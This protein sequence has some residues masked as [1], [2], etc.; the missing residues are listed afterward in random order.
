MEKSITLTGMHGDDN[1]IESVKTPPGGNSAAVP[2]VNLADPERWVEEHGDYLYAYAL[3]RVRDPVKAEDFVQET[4]LSGLKANFGG[5]SSEKSWLVGILKNKI[6]DYYRKL[7][8][9]TSF[10]DMEFLKDEQSECF[11][12][13]G[14]YKDLW[15]GSK[16]PVEWPD[17]G[18]SLDREEF[19]VVFNRCAGKLPKNVSQVFLLREMDDVDSKEICELLN[20]SQSNLWVMLHRA[21]MAL[22][23][24]L[25]MNWFGKKTGEERE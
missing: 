4:F 14:V 25:E 13:E 15:I 16:G 2:P 23:R 10:T 11:H 8:R 21:R 22:R 7:G 1:L 3:M 12:Q 20:I 19:W 6:F 18:A 5:R 17:P 9:E 24:C